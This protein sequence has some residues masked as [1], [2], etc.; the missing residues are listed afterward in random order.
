MLQFVFWLVRIT[1]S[2]HVLHMFHMQLL[3]D[4]FVTKTIITWLNT[5]HDQLQ[6]GLSQILWP[7]YI[8]SCKINVI[9]L[10]LQTIYCVNIVTTL[11]DIDLCSS[12]I[13]IYQLYAFL[14]IQLICSYILRFKPI[15]MIIQ[16]NLLRPTWIAYRVCASSSIT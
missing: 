14:P 7:H 13:D 1:F 2:Q 5:L 16:P 6:W 8:P 15:I 12:Y 3:R 4:L 9:F 10:T 11:C